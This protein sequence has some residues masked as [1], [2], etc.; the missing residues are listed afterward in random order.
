[1]P[2]KMLTEPRNI[3]I[4]LKQNVGRFVKIELVFSNVWVSISEVTF[5][6]TIAKGNYEKEVEPPKVKKEI[7]TRKTIWHEVTHSTRG[8][9]VLDYPRLNTKLPKGIFYL[10]YTIRSCFDI[11]KKNHHVHITDHS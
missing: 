2:D 7:S 6:S 4:D 11:Y 3:S 8:D 9:K 1:M 5:S 10:T